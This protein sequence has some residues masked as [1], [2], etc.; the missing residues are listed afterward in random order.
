M[1]EFTFVYERLSDKAYAVGAVHTLRN[2]Y[3]RLLAVSAVAENADVPAAAMHVVVALNSG[4]SIPGI[5]GAI[6]AYQEHQATQ[7]DDADAI[8]EAQYAIDYEY[9]NGMGGF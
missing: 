7:E 6:R 2:E 1:S 3:T 5:E 4:L 9:N 8:D